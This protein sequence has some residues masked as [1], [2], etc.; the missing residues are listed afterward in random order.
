MVLQD[1]VR[2][3]RNIS[4]AWMDEKKAYNSVDHDWLPNFLQWI[5]DTIKNIC[6]SWN[7]KIIAR[8]KNGIDTS[9]PICFK[10]DLPQGD[11]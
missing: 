7:I 9:K 6:A 5:S 3:R 8:T 1:Y 11:S 4:M 2:E 10:R